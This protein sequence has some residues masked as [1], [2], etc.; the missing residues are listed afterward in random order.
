MK[1]GIISI[2]AAIIF[3]GIF[4]VWYYVFDYS[5]THH[6][7]VENE[8]AIAVTAVQLVKDYQTDEPTANERYLNKALQVKGE[9]VKMDKD[10]SGNTTITLKSGDPFSNVFCTLKPNNSFTITDSVIVV[11]GICSGF[12]SDVV[13]NGAIVVRPAPGSK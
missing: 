10:Q 11:K 6:R 5:K 12:L 9:I 2:I 8:N 3:L 4:G 13:L 7:N 1:K